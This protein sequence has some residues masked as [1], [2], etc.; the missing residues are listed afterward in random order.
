MPRPSQRVSLNICDNWDEHPELLR[1]VGW[2]TASGLKPRIMFEATVDSH[3]WSIRINTFPDEP[4]FTLLIDGG[5]VIHLD[6]WPEI[7][8]KMPDSPKWG[9]MPNDTMKL[10]GHMLCV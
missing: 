8:G 5:E 10:T 3:D 6:Q 2:A 4:A 7:W 1:A 9:N